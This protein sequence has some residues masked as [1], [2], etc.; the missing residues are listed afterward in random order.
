MKRYG[1]ILADN[2]SN[3]YFQGTAERG[4]PNAMLDQLKAIPARAFVGVD[5]S[6]LGSIRWMA[7]STRGLA[8]PDWL[9][10]AEWRDAR[11]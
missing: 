7:V 5:E 1:L 2:G 8:W 9:L 4:W 10:E 11:R 6:G 3:W